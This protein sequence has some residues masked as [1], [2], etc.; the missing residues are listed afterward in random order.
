MYFNGWLQSTSNFRKNVTFFAVFWQKVWSCQK[1]VVPLQKITKVMSRT[2][3]D[4]LAQQWLESQPERKI[5][6]E[7]EIQHH[8][9]MHA[10]YEQSLKA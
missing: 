1:K 8:N 9:L 5:N 4:K 7:W 10:A 2:D 6:Y 3:Y